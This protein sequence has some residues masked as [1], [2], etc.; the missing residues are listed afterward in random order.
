[1][2]YTPYGQQ[3]IDEGTDRSII[4]YR[5]TSKEYDGETGLY[6]YGARYLDAV[7]A[8]WMT[9][10]PAFASLLPQMPINK[11]AR[12][13]NQNL[14]GDGGVFNYLN[15]DVYHYAQ[16]NPVQYSDPDGDIDLKA[17]VTT[18]ASFIPG[19][20]NAGYAA[21]YFAQGNYPAAA[22]HEAAAV[23]D[24]ISALLAGEIGGVLIGKAAG[25][26]GGLLGR[27]TSAAAESLTPNAVEAEASSILNVLKPGGKLIGTP[28][29]SPK[30][31]ILPGS[32]KEAEGL[33]NQLAKFGEP[34]EG[35][36]YPGQQI[37]LPGGGRI[38]LRSGG[39]SG[40]YPT[41]DVQGV[42]NL[43]IREIKFKPPE[44]N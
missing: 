26:V 29:S 2:E 25:I 38:G 10:E 9:P 8:R 13:N 4:T 11:Q 42:P 39:S 20:A 5:F 43:G 34:V 17:I 32:M 30:I 12:Q 19:N 1:M 31:R 21:K 7:T 40:P 35:S 36:G 3:W 28:G 33:F 24:G 15:L 44:E 16:N 22:V 27:G 37:E 41:I 14:P 23:V 18:A 6:Y